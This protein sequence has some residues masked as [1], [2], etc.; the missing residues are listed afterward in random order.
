[1]PLIETLSPRSTSAPESGIVEVFKYGMGREG[2]IPLWAGEGDSPTP[3]FISRAAA[4][5]LIA[6]ETFYTY[7][8]GI[9]TCARRLP[10]TMPAISERRSIPKTSSSRPPA[11]MPSR[12]L[13]R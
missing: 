12:L 6:G 2:L 5:A 9:R 3:D 8:R 10:V 11:C 1:M 4:D 13:P 7:Q